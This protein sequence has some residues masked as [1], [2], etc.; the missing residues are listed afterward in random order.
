MTMN[1][2]VAGSM[3]SFLL[4]AGTKGSRMALPHS[5]VLM[6]QP[7]GS[8]QG[9]S[10]DIKAE[11]EQLMRIKRTVIQNYAKMTNQSEFK[12]EKD[13]ERD[14]FMSAEEAL[15]YGIID[16]IVET[17]NRQDESNEHTHELLT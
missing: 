11:T 1:L 16:Y 4:A 17:E 3:A 7:M 12:I 2:G 6:H 9:S 13:I 14:F 8:A 15:E 5:R 10:L